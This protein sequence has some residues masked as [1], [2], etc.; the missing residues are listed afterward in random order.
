MPAQPRAVV[1]ALPAGGAGAAGACSG[2]AHRRAPT[3]SAGGRAG[4]HTPPR[5]PEAVPSS[6]RFSGAPRGADETRD[7]TYLL[8]KKKKSRVYETQNTFPPLVLPPNRLPGGLTPAGP[9]FPAPHVCLLRRGWVS[10]RPPAPVTY[11]RGRAVLRAP[12]AR[13]QLRAAAAASP[14]PPASPHPPAPR[15]RPGAGL[16]DLLGAAGT[17]FTI[18][19]SGRE[20]GGGERVCGKGGGN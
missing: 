7:Q 12:A 20:G 5:G 16:R 1:A 10:G 14:G 2:A 11:R 18:C 6:A 17:V 15:G 8:K 13:S 3:A 9:T 19:C 4:Q